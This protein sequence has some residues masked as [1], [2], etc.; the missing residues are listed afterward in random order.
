MIDN[1][2]YWLDGFVT[3]SRHIQQNQQDGWFTPETLPAW[4]SFVA[5]ALSAIAAFAASS[6]AKT[7][8]RAN[9][10]QAMSSRRLEILRISSENVAE[11][12]IVKDRFAFEMAQAKSDAQNRFK[13]QSSALVFQ[14]DKMVKETSALLDTM[15]S[16]NEKVSE[17]MFM[18]DQGDTHKW[19][20]HVRSTLLKKQQIAHAKAAIEL[21]V[22]EI[23]KKSTSLYPI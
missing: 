15:I 12:L 10:L 22:S 17:V 2:I 18:Q 9:A 14:I 4:G 3:A 20:D 7:A 16:A 6:A 11:L 13:E 1:L 8:N 23:K 21:K 19:D 5:A